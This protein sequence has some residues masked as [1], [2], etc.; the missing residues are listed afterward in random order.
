MTIKTIIIA[1]VAV[2]V[3][4]GGVYYATNKNDDQQQ[5]ES[6]QSSESNNEELNSINGLLAQNKNVTCTFSSADDSGS[7]T[8]GTVYV[9]GDRMRGN[10]SY[11]ASGKAEQ[12]S[13]IL[14]NSEYQYFWQ[15]GSDTGFKTKVDDSKESGDDSNKTDSQSQ[16]VDQDAKYE[17]DCSEWAVDE[18]KFSVPGS[19]KFTDYSAQIEQTK[20]KLSDDACDSITNEAAHKACENAVRS[21]N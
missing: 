6:S 7:Q 15:E 21:Q 13:N 19:V 12:Q 3:V 1:I 20:N 14:R 17:F 16:S 18:S 9:A 2:A 5:S 11:Q 4:G 10:F 8:S